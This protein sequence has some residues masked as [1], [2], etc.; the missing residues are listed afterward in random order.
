MVHT[1]NHIYFKIIFHFNF[2]LNVTAVPP[3]I[4][5]FVLSDES[6][7]NFIFLPCHA[8]N[9]N[10]CYKLVPPEIMPFTFGHD[11]FNAGDSTGVSCMIV[12]GDLPI[13]IKWTLNSSPITSNNDI[14]ITVIK[15][16]SKT[17]VLN[18]GSLDEHHRGVFKCI[19]E[20]SAGV[21]DYASELHVNGSY[22]HFD[23]I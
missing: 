9:S 18:I 1:T 19:A 11:S 13:N 21:V 4:S 16:S 2:N 6:F 23:K 17:S 8:I 12:K 14:G 3:K 5:P 10:Q 15:L 22:Q 20:N 7:N